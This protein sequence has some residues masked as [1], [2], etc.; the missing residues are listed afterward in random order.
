MSQTPEEIT[1]QLKDNL[2]GEVDNNDAQTAGKFASQLSE[3]L[4]EEVIEVDDVEI[5]Q[6]FYQ[7]LDYNVA[8]ESAKTTI[9]RHL[10]SQEDTE[11]SEILNR[12]QDDGVED[13]NVEDIEEADN[14]INVEVKVDQIWDNDTDVLSQ[15]GLAYDETGRIKFKAWEESQKPLLA[16]GQSYRLER[17]ATDEF[18]GN[19]EIS[20]NSETNVE[21]LDEDIEMPDRTETFTGVLVDIQTGSGLI[22]R[23]TSE[24]CNRVLDNGSCQE[25]GDVEGEFDLRIKGVLDNGHT[26]QGVVLNREFTEQ[27]SGVRLEEAKSMAKE[28]FDTSVVTDEISSEVLLRY[29]EVEGWTSDYGDMIAEEVEEVSDVGEYDVSDLVQ[30]LT[31]LSTNGF[32]Q[33]DLTQVN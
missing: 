29:Y 14:F 28:A 10:A 32:E 33:E 19:M 25:H 15:V 30:R 2:D 24:G 20:I 6:N 21:M 17:V 1:E 31:A 5:A 11:V 26:T 18:Q 4:D 9:L 23:C 22:R 3:E 8:P 13:L 12:S 16:E 7:Y 27:I